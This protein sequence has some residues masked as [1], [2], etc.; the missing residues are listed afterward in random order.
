MAQPIPVY[1]WCKNCEVYGHSVVDCHFLH[2]D[3]TNFGAAFQAA[4]GPAL[5]PK[6][7]YPVAH[8]GKGKK[9]LF[10]TLIPRRHLNL[11]STKPIGYGA[12]PTG[13]ALWKRKC[14]ASIQPV[15]NSSRVL[16]QVTLID[17]PVQ[18][19]ERVTIG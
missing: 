18:C 8:W 9:K 1:V 16:P 6:N 10:V 2:E 4:Q 11:S 14:A 13:R 12:V 5:D 15:S 7:P 19:E 17:T 3:L